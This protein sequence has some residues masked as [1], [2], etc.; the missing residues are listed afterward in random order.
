M[1]TNTPPTPSYLPFRLRV[2]VATSSFPHPL[3]P[4]PSSEGNKHKGRVCASRGRLW[5]FCLRRESYLWVSEGWWV[6][7]NGGLSVSGP[8]PVVSTFPPTF[9]PLHFG[10]SS[11]PTRTLVVQRRDRNVHRKPVPGPNR[12]VT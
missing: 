7:D 12:T 4:T 9:T 5:G 2:A 11:V 1:S 10:G 6:Q 3:S 8:S